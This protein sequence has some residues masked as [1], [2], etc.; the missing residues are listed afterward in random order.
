MVEIGGKIWDNTNIATG[1]GEKM[2][3]LTGFITEDG[4]FRIVMA[5]TTELA[6]YLREIH[7]FS[8]PVMNAVSRFIS[9]AALLSSSLK[10]GDVIGVYLN[11][12]GPLEGI[13]VEVNAIGQLK[14]FAL[15]PQAGID[16]IDSDY[17]MPLPQLIGEGILTVSRIMETGRTPFSGT[18]Q[19]EGDALAIGFSRY[20]MDSEQVRSAV[21]ISH[22]LESDGRAKASAGMLV[23]ALPGAPD[24][25]LEEMES[26][27]RGFP[28]FSQI[29]LELD[30]ADQTIPLLFAR[31]KVRRLFQRPLTFHCSCSREKVVRIL[32]SLP[33][34]DLEN[35]RQADGFFHVNCDY[36]RTEY[37]VSEEQLQ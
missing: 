34:E 6:N 1:Q 4:F 13:R 33:R 37:R 21:L 31:F 23:Q 15:Q 32:K 36:C 24:D 30:T 12:S 18:V 11:C 20:L 25:K 16:E 27:I 14:G 28:P 8:Y 22:F 7:S 17:V 9:G 19:V 35:V 5:E 2:A 10:G 3:Q 29:I 26:E